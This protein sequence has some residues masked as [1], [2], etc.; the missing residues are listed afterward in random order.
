MIYKRHLPHIQPP[1]AIMFITFRLAGSLP[2]EIIDSIKSEY[3]R[4]NQIIMRKPSSRKDAL[5]ERRKLIFRY[6][7]YLHKEGTG[8]HYLK[9]VEVAKMVCDSIHFHDQSLYDL[10]AFC[11]MSNH[12][13][14]VLKPKIIRDDDFVPIEK[15]THSIKSFAQVRRIFYL[16]EMDNFGPMKV[17]IIIPG[18]MLR[19]KILFST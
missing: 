3:N 13:H 2:K 19:Q 10:N 4:L 12:V 7:H 11:V 15:I 8:P 5:L 9:D 1:G 17:L 14:I 6:D 16:T 18:Q